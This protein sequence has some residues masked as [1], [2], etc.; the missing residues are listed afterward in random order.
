MKKRPILIA[1][2]AAL[3]LTACASAPEQRSP[4]AFDEAY[5]GA[6]E[7]HAKNAGVE[8][9]WINPPRKA[10]DTNDRG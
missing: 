4:Y 7:A 8:V 3:F 9:Y 5:I 2:A 6:V 1:A 10:R